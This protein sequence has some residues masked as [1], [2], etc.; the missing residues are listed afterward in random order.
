VGQNGT[1]DRDLLFLVRGQSDPEAIG[2]LFARHAR[3]LERFLAA[4]TRDSSVAAELTAE[5]FAV[6]LRSAKRFRGTTDDE[7][8][9]FLYGV[10]RN[11]ARAWRRRG[12]VDHAARSRLHMPV[13]DPAD[14]VS[15]VEERAAAHVLAPRL[16][17]AVRALPG[18]QRAA[19]E[20]R[21]VEEL[22]YGEVASRLGCSE[23]AARQRVARGLRTLRERLA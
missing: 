7:A 10:A 6:V 4:E 20:L 9:S 21:V 3:G 8:V 1:I 5:T 17:L 2:E 11:L 16:A 23:P 19:V 22:S 14:H 18:D 12:R 13:R 15:E